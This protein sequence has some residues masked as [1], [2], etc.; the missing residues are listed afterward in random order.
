M[1]SKLK[2]LMSKFQLLQHRTFMLILKGNK[3]SSY[4]FLCNIIILSWLFRDIKFQFSQVHTCLGFFAWT[5]ILYYTS[6]ITKKNST[7]SNLLGNYVVYLHV[8]YSKEEYI[9]HCNCV[10]M[11]YDMYCQKYTQVYL[12]TF[13][14]LL[15]I[16]FF[17]TLWLQYSLK[18]TSSCTLGVIIHN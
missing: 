11:L 14:W 10:W 1:Q 15:H 5:L 2:K 18:Y 7:G 3:F 17:V 8:Q 12:F 9:R 6:R 16:I 4:P 13:P